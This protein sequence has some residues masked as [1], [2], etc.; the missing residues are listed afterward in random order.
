VRVSNVLLPPKSGLGGG[1]DVREIPF[2]LERKYWALFSEYEQKLE[3]VVRTSK[4]VV[5]CS[6]SLQPLLRPGTV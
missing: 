6:Y 1:Q 3:Q 5:L 2:W 4:I